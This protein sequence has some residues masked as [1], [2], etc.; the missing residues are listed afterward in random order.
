MIVDGCVNHPRF[1]APPRFLE[2]YSEARVATLHF[3][4]GSYAFD[5]EDSRGYYYR[6][7]SGVLEHTAAGPRRREGGIFVSK[8]NRDRLRGYV[9]MPYGLTH[10]GNLSRTEHEFRD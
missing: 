1:A 4:R 8:R 3:P 9:I 6:A 7:P 2:L 5:S 10:V